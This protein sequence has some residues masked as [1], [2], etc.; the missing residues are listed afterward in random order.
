MLNLHRDAT[1]SLRLLDYFLRLV[2]DLERRA[3]GNDQL[4][5]SG[6]QTVGARTSFPG[7]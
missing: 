6:S 3:T 2:V 5:S 4:T 1:T 7:R